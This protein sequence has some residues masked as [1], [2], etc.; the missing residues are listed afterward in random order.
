M[1]RLDNSKQNTYKER[2]ENNYDCEVDGHEI[3]IQP[4][5]IIHIK[6]CCLTYVNPVNFGKILKV[7]FGRCIMGGVIINSAVLVIGR[8]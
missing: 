7:T 5:N 3:N 8:S 6:Y 1:L 4:C 2:K